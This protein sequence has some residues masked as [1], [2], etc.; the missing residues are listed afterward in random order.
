MISSFVHDIASCQLCS[1]RDVEDMSTEFSLFVRPLHD[2]SAPP[3]KFWKKTKWSE[4]AVSGLVKSRT[5]APLV[6]PGDD[7]EPEA[8]ECPICCIVRESF[9]WLLPNLLFIVLFFL[10][11][12]L[13]QSYPGGM[14]SIQCCR[15]LICSDCFFS[16]Q[17]PSYANPYV[18][19]GEP[20]ASGAS[21]VC[22]LYR[23][24]FC[25]RPS[26]RAVSVARE[27]VSARG[28]EATTAAHAERRHRCV[29]LVGV[30]MCVSVYVSVSSY[31][32]LQRNVCSVSSCG[33]CVLFVCVRSVLR[34]RPSG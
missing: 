10:P 6:P 16:L 28:K 24:P 29:R 30:C 4:T 27:E 26:F 18:F 20:P 21:P 15:Q 2:C 19:V 5:L 11:T 14:N 22:G 9:H 7:D 1:P 32:C 13:L 33:L 34:R 23:C 3:E 12:V 17:V 25:S 8:E 31:A